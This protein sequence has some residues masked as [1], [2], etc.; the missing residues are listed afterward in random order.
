MEP[1]GL[2]VKAWCQQGHLGDWGLGSVGL[3]GWG[4][5][6]HLGTWM[7]RCWGLWGLGAW[8]PRLG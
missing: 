8:G 7:T 2:E 5:W 3:G 6:G 4:Q 1:V